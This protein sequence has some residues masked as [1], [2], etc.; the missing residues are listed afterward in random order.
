MFVHFYVLHYSTH[1]PTAEQIGLSVTMAGLTLGIYYLANGKT[2]SKK[3]VDLERKLSHAHKTVKDLEEK[4]FGLEAK[5]IKNHVG[6]K[7]VRIWMDG[8]FDMMHYG[9]MNAFRQGRALGTTLI[10]GVNSDETI[11]QCKGAPVMNTFERCEAV[12]GCKFVDEVVPN[13]PYI[14]NDEYLNYVIQKYKIDYVVHG[15]DP[16]VVN[17]RDVYE[18]AQKL[19]KY[20]TI[21]RTEGISTTDIVGRMLLM[22][23]SHHSGS[24]DQM[25]LKDSNDNDSKEFDY[26]KSN[27]LTTSRTIRLFGAGVTAPSRDAKVVYLAG[28]W[29]MFHAGHIALLK[30]ARAYGDY[31]IVG[32]HNDTVT[33]SNRGMN[34]PIM[35]LHERVLSVLACKH[36]DDVLI[37][38][39]YVIT[40]EMIASLKISKVIQGTVTEDSNVI[41]HPLPADADSFIDP[42]VVPKEMGIY[43]HIKSSLEITV[44]D[45][46]QRIQTQRSRFNEKFK[47]KK[48]AEDEYYQNKYYSSTPIKASAAVEG[49]Y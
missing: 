48:V 13:V 36:V 27:F 6:G 19:G 16:C 24:L 33:N 25:D 28:A 31:V 15:D 4:L 44:L 22:T 30:A 40:S 29:D 9:H 8:A 45:I 46:V 5:D 17:G 37:D 49:I 38:A 32:V 41:D 3:R 14:M 42:Y 23:K 12:S 35:N 47:V 1:I 11:T 43:I 34:L 20:L 39:P 26:R 18:S 21:P 10:V 7:E 2:N